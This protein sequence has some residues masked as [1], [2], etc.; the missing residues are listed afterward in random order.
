[1]DTLFPDVIPLIASGPGARRHT[2]F[3]GLLPPGDVARRVHDLADGLRQSGRASGKLRPERVLHVSLA[4]LG[5]ELAEPPSSRLIDTLNTRAARVGQ[6]PFTVCLNRVESWGGVDGHVVAV[7]G[8]GV[9]SVETLHDNLVAALGSP[10][11]PRFTPHM[12]LLYGSGPATPLPIP[13]ITWVVRDFALIHSFV[14][15][16]QYEVLGR[17]PLSDDPAP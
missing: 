14:G 9:I 5:K 3:F 15:L 10:K 6:R 1:M 17:F 12:T 7:G 2:L 16:T 4:L 11:R 8:D 13:P